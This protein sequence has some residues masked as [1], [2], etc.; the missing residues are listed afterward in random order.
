MSSASFRRSALSLQWP[1]T[2]TAEASGESWRSNSG[3]VYWWKGLCKGVAYP[4]IPGGKPRSFTRGTKP[5][6][7]ATASQTRLA[8]ATSRVLEPLTVMT[9]RG[10]VIKQLDNAQQRK[11]VTGMRSGVTI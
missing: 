11:T 6:C 3:D 10:V 7:A 4:V 9:V 1:M 8:R 5:C 2:I